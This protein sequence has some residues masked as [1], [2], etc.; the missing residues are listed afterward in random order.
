VD[1]NTTNSSAVVVV[2][3]ATVTVLT[4]EAIATEHSAI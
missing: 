4:V 1:A 2:D 3:Y